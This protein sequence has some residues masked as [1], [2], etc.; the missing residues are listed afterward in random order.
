MPFLERNK[1]KEEKILNELLKTPEG[2]RAHEEYE[3]EYSFRKALYKARK[4]RDISQKQL[5]EITGLS[6]QMISRIETGWCDTKV[7]TLLKY[8]NG[9]GYSLKVVKNEN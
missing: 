2:K 7:G 5:S 6:Q 3:A 4:N 1:E 8:L 9:I